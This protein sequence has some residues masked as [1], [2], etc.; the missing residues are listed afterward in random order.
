MT[1][2]GLFAIL[3]VLAL[4][5]WGANT[6]PFIVGQFRTIISW[7]LVAVAV[8]CLVIFILGVFG[9]ALPHG[10]ATLRLY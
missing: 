6:A 1:V 10:N 8:V 3:V 9:V 7:F 5:Y 4:L 2:L